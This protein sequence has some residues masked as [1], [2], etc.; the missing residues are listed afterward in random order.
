M[1]AGLT[2]TCRFHVLDVGHERGREKGTERVITSYSL[3]NLQASLILE[4][5]FYDHLK[6]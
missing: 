1:K 4:M 2:F 3:K 6:D 5:H